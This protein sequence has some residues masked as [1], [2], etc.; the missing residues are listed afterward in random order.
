MAAV[1]FKHVDVIFGKDQKR[2]AALLDQGKNRNEILA[3]TGS[4]LG[5]ADASLVVEEG[6]ICVLMGLSGSGKSSLLRC[7]NGLNPV[8]RGELLIA[9]QG[10]SVDMAKI[11]SSK[12]RELRRDRIA[13]VFQQ[14]GLLPWCTVRDNVGF[15]LSVKGMP[16]EEVARIAN[17][18]LALVNLTDWAD[19]QVNELSGGMQQRVGL[20][21]AF[22]TDADILLMDE[23]FS[24]LDPLIRDRLQDELLELQKSLKRTIIFVSHDLNEALKLGNQI[25]IMEGGR[26]IQAGTARDIIFKPAN[27]YVRRFVANINPLNVLYAGVLMQPLEQFP[28]THQQIDLGGSWQLQL[29]AKGEP[30]SLSLNG[31]TA[32][33]KTVDYDTWMRDVVELA[34]ATDQP[35]LVTQSG[36]VVGVITHKDLLHSLLRQADSSSEHPM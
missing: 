24:A 5:V 7:V 26:I 9:H 12:L 30:S 13:M 22:A 4:V 19:K 11:S 33:L 15:G 1:E 23:P 16:K 27:E 2:A 25:V 17:E 10:G 6:T 34:Q 31:Q 32:E 8:T 18:K 3:E 36:K 20:A 35:L 29:D 28:T 14:F 21:R